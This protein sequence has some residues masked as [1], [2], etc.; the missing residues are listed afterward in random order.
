[1]ATD[2][3]ARYAKQ[4]ASHMGR[5]AATEWDE[6][7]GQGWIQFPTGKATLAAGDDVLLVAL[8]ADDAESRDRLEG[9]VGRHLVRF[10]A[11]DELVCS[12]V[13]TDGTQGS[14]QRNDAD[15]T[16]ADRPQ[17]EER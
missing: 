4:W 8:V 15:E 9:V 17:S 6:D 10:G 7:A 3:P 16:P 5:T 11:K 14:E 2:R 13:R 12:W 1:M